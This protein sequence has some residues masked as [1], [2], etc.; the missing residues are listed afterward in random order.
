MNCQELTQ[1]LDDGD[2]RNIPP[3]R[4]RQLNEHLSGCP[5]CAAEWR[6]QERIAMTPSMW[7]PAGFVAQCRQ[8]VAAGA[9]RL[10]A[11]RRVI[12]YST[13]LVLAAAAALLAWRYSTPQS[14]SPMIAEVPAI[15]APVPAPA[16]VAPAPQPT[17]ELAR[18][19]RVQLPAGVFAV[20][21]PP[22]QTVGNDAEGN[23]LAA[24][25][26]TRVISLL[27]SVPNLALV[28]APSG[29]P[30]VE[31]YQLRMKYMDSGSVNPLSR[32]MELE[33]GKSV[34]F[35]ATEAAIAAEA[36]MSPEDRARSQSARRSADIAR[37]AASMRR[38]DNAGVTL[39]LGIGAPRTAVISSSIG[40][41]NPID[42]MP[43]RLVRDLRVNVFPLDE[44]FEQEELAILRNP[45]EKEALRMRSLGALLVYA[46]RR[47]GFS[48]ASPAVVRAGGEFALTFQGDIP[49]LRPV[50][51]DALALTGS[52]ELVPYLVRGLDEVALTE[53][54]LQLVKILIENYADDPR[55]KAALAAAA[56]SNDQETVRMAAMRGSN[57]SAWREYVVTALSN[58]RLPDLQ[59]LQP[60][61]DMAP[62]DLNVLR[63]GPKTRMVLEKQQLRELGALVIKVAP[64]KMAVE[65]A[66]KA[67]FAA[68]GMETPAALEMLLNVAGSLH[69]EDAP[70]GFERSSIMEVR[71]TARSLIAS[72]YA[73][74]PRAR[75][76]IDEMASGS[77]PFEREEAKIR[78]MIL[79]SK[80][81]LEKVGSQQP[82]R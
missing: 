78:L 65:T 11:P 46:E 64:D 9:V 33:I 75:A 6:V 61:A 20:Y 16:Q 2:I 70:P 55:A 48:H 45:A 10:F 21:V 22:L 37:R 35:A 53:T 5:D 66:R 7:V 15:A 79:N 80:A 82:A 81:S 8:L 58:S 40:P 56:K 59:R 31:E 36:R 28:D 26:R 51:W 30:E 32:S 14:T 71:G 60:I 19:Q 29:S 73:G 43:Q 34:E 12:L 13:L 4:R 72:R 1:L 42:S 62:A 76:L 74:D 47:G 41:T 67:L 18:P 68:A 44:S 69:M 54:R 23:A 24:L 39:L 3:A 52:P 38:G 57:E 63:A 17:V 77:D 50:V 49:M 25:F 27:Q